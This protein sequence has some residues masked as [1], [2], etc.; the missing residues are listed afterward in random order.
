MP[1]WKVGLGLPGQREPSCMAA[2][3][4]AGQPSLRLG[5]LLIGRVRELHSSDLESQK[6]EVLW[7]F[8]LELLPS[9]L[10]TALL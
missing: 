2:S 10:K 4:A 6:H 7:R 8:I 9:L 5:S 3:Q 1:S